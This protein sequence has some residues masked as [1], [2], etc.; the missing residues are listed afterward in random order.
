MANAILGDLVASV[1]Q[2]LAGEALRELSDD[3]LLDRYKRG[4]QDAF[5]VLVERHAPLVL[6]VCRRMLGTKGDVEDAFQATFLILARRAGSV[7]WEKCIRGWL[8]R[9]AIHVARRA[10]QR[11]EREREL[12][13]A[14]AR[15]EQ[16]P[17]HDPTW[18]EG[19]ACIDEELANLPTNYRDV[20]LACCV[21]GKS[22]DE[23]GAELGLSG[24][25]VKGLLERARD[26]L[27]YR[28]A[29]RGVVLP[30]AVL[31]LLLQHGSAS[32]AGPLL[33][34]TVHASLAYAAGQSQAVAPAVLTLAQGV[35]SAMS[36]L[37]SLWAASISLVV[38][39]AAVV[40]LWAGSTQ[41]EELP[42][43]P[44]IVLD[45][46]SVLPVVF[47][48]KKDVLAIRGILV[49][50]DAA[51]KTVTIEVTN[52]TKTGEATTEKMTFPVADNADVAINGKPVKLTDIP[53]VNDLTALQI[54]VTLKLT[55]DRKT[56]VALLVGADTIEKKKVPEVH[57]KL[58]AVSAQQKSVTLEVTTKNKT[59]EVTVEKVNFTLAADATI[60]LDGKAIKLEELKPGEQVVVRLTEDKKLVTNLAVGIVK[61][62][63]VP[64]EVRGTLSAVDIANNTVTIEIPPMKTKTGEELPG[65]KL[66]VTGTPDSKI[67]LSG[68]PARLNDLKVGEPV[69]VRLSEDR[70]TILAL[71]VRPEPKNPEKPHAD[72]KGTLKGVD[73][74]KQTL[75]LELPG[76]GGNVIEKTFKVAK[77]CAITISGKPGELKDV[78][79]GN[80]ISVQINADEAV[81]KIHAGEPEKK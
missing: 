22:R 10:R 70:K 78:K 28:L 73:V 1:R 53:Q 19:L 6:S 41:N 15:S 67:L 34:A 8:Y 30:A 51:K 72:I 58:A 29:Q 47:Q 21:E 75:T 23:A 12:E 57:G 24:G 63:K 16:T 36:S 17:A 65:E 9:V 64:P 32:A 35:L 31:I 26:L 20:L 61:E 62:G 5:S 18:Q 81:L 27:R 11:G 56:V 40:G 45:G 68:Q 2:R 25:Q 52:K 80:V 79:V 74:E 54:A 4:D 71:I 39:L 14:A 37:K 44:V 49:S 42:K 69:L 50:V 38:T 43:Q 7:R 48:E 3:L 59:G 46:D 66:T 60:T 13:R 33:G 76:K 77:D 55:E